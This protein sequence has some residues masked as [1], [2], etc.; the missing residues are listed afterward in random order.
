MT[1][2]K[3]KDGTPD[4]KGADNTLL[5]SKLRSLE[6]DLSAINTAR[7]QRMIFS[8]VGGALIIIALVMFLLNISNFFK[9]KANSPEFQEELLTKSLN[10]MKELKNNKNLQKIVSDL[11]QKVLPALAKE[12]ARQFKNE[13]PNF[14]A[15]GDDFI[16]ELRA[17]F[18]NDAKKR[19]ETSLLAYLVKV[20][21]TLKAHYPNLSTDDL[22]KLIESSQSVF[23]LELDKVLRK[24]LNIV[25]DDLVYLQATTNQFKECPEYRQLNPQDKNSIHYAKLQL[26]VSMLELAIF[27]IDP[28]RGKVRFVDTVGGVK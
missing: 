24:K 3:K 25:E 15:K 19:I 18:E 17:F 5:L 21:G 16:K 26:I 11:K 7:S 22:N 13:I 2:Q 9:E 4:G 1:D 10:D 28:D 20:E 14:R 6:K 12:V 27:H 23:I 8:L